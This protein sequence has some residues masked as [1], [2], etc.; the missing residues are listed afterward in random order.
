MRQYYEQTTYNFFFHRNLLRNL[1]LSYK[2]SSRHAAYRYTYT[3]CNH[4]TYTDSR[5]FTDF[6]TGKGNSSSTDMHLTIK[7]KG[8]VHSSFQ[9]IA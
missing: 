3:A 5:A 6:H 7:A 8:F 4:A 9:S 2:I 1:Y